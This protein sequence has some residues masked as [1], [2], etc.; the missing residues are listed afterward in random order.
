M[1]E[2]ELV[3]RLT[4]HIAQ[5]APHQKERD[6]GRLLIQ[7]TAALREHILHVDSLV[8]SREA[9]TEPAYAEMTSRDRLVHAVLCAYAKHHL[10]IPDIGWEQLGNILHSVICNEIGDAAYQAWGERIRQG[11]TEEETGSEDEAAPG[12]N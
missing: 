2:Q 4:S 6:G 5:M 8:A 7:A 1:N 12:A 9:L 11:W 10:E 3:Q